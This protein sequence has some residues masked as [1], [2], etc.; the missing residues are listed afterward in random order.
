MYG[1]ALAANLEHAGSYGL[2]FSTASTR[3]GR[4][5]I[6]GQ[7]QLAQASGNP[8]LTAET[9][10]H[11]HASTRKI[12]GNLRPILHLPFLVVIP[13]GN[14]RSA[15]AHTR[16]PSTEDALPKEKTSRTGRSLLKQRPGYCM[17]TPPWA[18]FSFFNSLALRAPMAFCTHIS[19]WAMS[20]LRASASVQS[21]SA[22]RR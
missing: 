14:L 16:L 6:F 8:D 9:Q 1:L 19:T 21:R 11:R 13:E 12:Q 15:S 17:V 10:P 4:G 20:A 7:A 22:L 2:R 18:A 3:E 5:P